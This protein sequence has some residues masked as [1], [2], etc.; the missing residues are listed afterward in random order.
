MYLL[1]RTLRNHEGHRLEEYEMVRFVSLF[2]EVELIIG[3]ILE[4]IK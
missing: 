1:K 2:L 3:I 4:C